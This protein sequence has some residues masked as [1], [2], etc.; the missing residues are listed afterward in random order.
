MKEYKLVLWI[1]CAAAVAIA[2]ATAI[3]IFWDEITDGY[4]ELKGKIDRKFLHR[5]EE[6]SDYADM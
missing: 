1:I 4:T 2:A 6:F 5:K 3:I